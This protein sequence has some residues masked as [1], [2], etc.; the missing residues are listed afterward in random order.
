MIHHNIDN[1]PPER[2]KSVAL[3][4]P[5]SVERDSINIIGNSNS[6]QLQFRVTSSIPLNISVHF[7]SEI[8]SEKAL[9]KIIPSQQDQVA[10][11][12][13]IEACQ[14]KSITIQLGILQSKNTKNNENEEDISMAI[15]LKRKDEKAQLIT[16]FQ[17]DHQ[18]SIKT[19]QQSFFYKGSM[20]Q[21]SDIYG[22]GAIEP[23]RKSFQEEECVICFNGAKN[24]VLLPCRHLCMCQNCAEASQGGQKC[25]ICRTR[26]A[27]FMR[28][29][30]RNKDEVQV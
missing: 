22:G 14:N 25:P 1:T 13:N 9:L 27:T 21:L 12:E 7:Y 26:V 4:V 10:I 5:F 28:I 11:E 8:I 29:G 6:A 18:H 20:F 17:L 15:V 23:F 16:Q 3:K 19:I 30:L 2:K 24:M